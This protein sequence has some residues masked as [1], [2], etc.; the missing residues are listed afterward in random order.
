MCKAPMPRTPRAKT[1]LTTS[2]VAMSRRARVEGVRVMNE[3][4]ARPNPHLA[5][6]MADLEEACEDWDHDAP[7]FLP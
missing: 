6:A 5:G 4:E 7:A 1:T 2:R 3:R